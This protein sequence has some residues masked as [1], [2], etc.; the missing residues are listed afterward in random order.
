MRVLVTR[1][2]PDASETAARLVALGHK[3]VVAPL[4][5]IDYAEGPA[6]SLD[7]VAAFVA[8]SANGVRALTRRTD[9]RD[10]VLFAVGQQTA[11]L[12]RSSGFRMVHSA[13]GDAAALAALVKQMSSP[14]RGAVLHA[15]GAEAE[16]KLA[17]DLTA[18]GFEVRTEILYHARAVSVLPQHA[19]AAL[20]GRTLDAVLHFSYRSAR[21]F[22]DVVTAGGLAEACRDLLMVCIS[23]AT[24]RSLE[25]FPHRELR[26]AAAPNQDA[27]LAGL[28]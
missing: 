9:R 25:G 7:R 17:H 8:T 14:A 5:A 23:A 15:A 16:G 24:A 22:R 1:P 12:A 20:D 18:A 28:L 11:S 19:R 13:N 6:L 27:L 4:L 10:I 3:P 21:T 26:V 2:E